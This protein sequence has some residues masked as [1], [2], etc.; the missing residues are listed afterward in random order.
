M[1]TPIYDTPTSSRDNSDRSYPESS[2]DS[3]RGSPRRPR[4][5][6][7]DSEDEDYRSRPRNPRS[8]SAEPSYLRSPRR[9]EYQRDYDDREERPPYPASDIYSSQDPPGA[10]SIYSGHRYPSSSHNERLTPGLNDSQ[11][12]RRPLSVGSDILDE[13]HKYL[14]VLPPAP[15]FCW[16][17]CNGR[18]KAVCVSGLASYRRPILF[19]QDADWN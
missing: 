5:V 11:N 12:L 19:T 15:D 8:S 17:K 1:V 2:S 6:Y 13:V 10:S 7:T 16:S 14:K 18:K 3:E 9:D 4:A